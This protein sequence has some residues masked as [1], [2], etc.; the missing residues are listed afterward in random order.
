MKTIK[1][2]INHNKTLKIKATIRSTTYD[3]L[4]NLGITIICGNPGST[5]ETFL[6]NIMY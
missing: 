3:A 6:M 4:R 2:K 1:S 5:K